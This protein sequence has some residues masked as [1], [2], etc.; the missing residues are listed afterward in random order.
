MPKYSRMQ[1][2]QV[3]RDR[4]EEETTEAQQVQNEQPYQRL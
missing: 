2:Y 1:R 4:L 3:L